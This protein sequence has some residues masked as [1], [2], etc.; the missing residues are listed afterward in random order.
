[1]HFDN[2]ECVNS[3][4]SLRASSCT[5][6][7]SICSEHEANPI[8]LHVR[9]HT[10]SSPALLDASGIARTCTRLAINNQIMLALALA[11]FDMPLLLA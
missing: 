5:R 10:L 7:H 2:G 9:L 1:M 8:P 4:R 6:T 3:S 11:V